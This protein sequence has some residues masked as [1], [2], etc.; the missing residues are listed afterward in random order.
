MSRTKFPSQNKV[1]IEISSRLMEK[2]KQLV[3]FPTLVECH[4]AIASFD[5]WMSKGAYDVFALVINFC[6][7]LATKACDY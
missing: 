6:Q 2:T 5:L 3:V 7:G 4:F 1:F